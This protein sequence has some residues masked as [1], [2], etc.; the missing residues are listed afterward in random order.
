[1]LAR[2]L[3]EKTL[4]PLLVIALMTP[5]LNRPYSAE[6]PDVITWVSSMASSMKSPF[7]VPNRLSLMSTPSTR[8]TLS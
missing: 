7:E 3:P 4:P 6:M 5:P 8:K 2:K 1:M